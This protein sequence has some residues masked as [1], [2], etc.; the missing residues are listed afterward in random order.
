MPHVLFFGNQKEFATRLI[1]GDNG[2]KV[3]LVLVP[4]FSSTGSLA[5]I[6]LRTLD[7]QKMTFQTYDD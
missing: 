1:E 7:C 3:R 2:Q 5:L 6:D 4:P